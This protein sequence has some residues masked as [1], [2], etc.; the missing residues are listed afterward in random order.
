MFPPTTYRSRR[1]SLIEQERPESG[2]ALLL[3]N[4][5]S[6]RNY[7]AN[8]H[9]FWQD[10]TFLYYFG[11]DRPGLYGLID[12]DEGTSALYGGETTLDDAIWAGEQPAFQEAAATAGIDTTA[13]SSTLESRLSDARRQDRPIHILPPYRDEHR[14]RFGALLDC[15]PDQLEETVSEPLIR[16]VLRQRSVKTAEEVAEIETAL[17]H[18]A[19]IHASARRHAVPGAHE[20]ELVGAMTNLLTTEGSEF[21]FTPTCSVRGEVLHNHSYSNTLAEGDLLLVDA[22]ATSPR[23]YAGDVTRV[24]PVGDT[25]TARQEALYTAVLSTQTDAIDALAPGVP[26]VNVHKRAAQTLT[27]HLID[28]GLM[29]GPAEEAVRTGAH[30]LFFPHGLGH[31]LGL[32]VHDMESLGEDIVGY[33]EDQTRSEQFGLHTLRL[34]RPLRPGFVV[35]V[36]PGCYFI[37]PL[38]EHWRAE[39]RH[40]RFINYDR[41]E[42]FLGIGGIRIEDD[43][44]I[45]QEGA[46]ILGPDIPKAPEAVCARVGTARA[47]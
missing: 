31:M 43:V 29:Q 30:A 41:V 13:S 3:G 38:V 21:S 19:R 12:L 25:F 2:L 39:G 24:T 37:P 1:R 34:A 46:R 26:F 6:P 9:P 20:R 16:A 23:H 27:E 17:E 18:T 7:P 35:T 42:D 8:P 10:A 15:P 40:D 32:D 36:E 14:L 47:N 4:R 33:A 22:G 44:L 5:R 28:L 11:L 45:T